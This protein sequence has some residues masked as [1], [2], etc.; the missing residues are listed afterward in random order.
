[1][2]QHLSDG[3]F[4]SGSEI[5]RLFSVSRTAVW[6]AL[7]K[8]E[9]FGVAVESHKGK[10]YRILGGLDLLDRSAI[11]SSLSA[12][13]KARIAEFLVFPAVDSTNKLLMDSMARQGEYH[14]VTTEMQTAGRGR[15]GKVWVSPFAKNVYL[16]IGFELHGGPEALSGLSLVAG[17]SV[18]RA[19]GA[20]GVEGAQLKWPNDI[21]VDGRKLAGILVELQGEATTSWQVVVGVGLNVKM[22]ERDGEGIDQP[23]VA[24]DELASLRRSDIVASMVES[25]VS[26]IEQFKRFG[27]SAFR[28][29]WERHDLICG[30]DVQVNEGEISGRAIGVD[31][32]GALKI[33]TSSGCVVVN[34]GEVSVRPNVS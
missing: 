12:D 15:R 20:L 23:W 8:L 14:L 21:W 4:H 3:K 28:E 27:F 19:L 31:A 5:G 26:I 2:L 17:I 18:V 10:G 11:L 34:A 33:D 25:L 22:S 29:E 30:N 13:V 7:G 6:K 16:S 32:V 24:L 1:M 9:E